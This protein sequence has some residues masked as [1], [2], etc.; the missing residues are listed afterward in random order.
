MAV[1]KDVTIYVD[2]ADLSGELNAAALDLGSEMLDDTR[3]GA[4]TRKNTAGLTTARMAH[5]GYWRA[6]GVDGPDDFLFPNLGT[7]NVPATL[8]PEGASMGG[9]AFFFRTVQG[10]YSLGGQ[11]GALLP[12]S[13]SAEG[14]DGV[15]PTRGKVLQPAGVV[16]ATGTGAAVEIGAAGSGQTIYAALHVLSASGTSPTLDVE[17][18]SDVD[19]TFGTPVTALT[20]GQQSAV[21]SDWQTVAGPNADTHYR[22][23]YTVGGTN[24]EFSFVVVVGII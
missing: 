1:L 15:P 16:T 18:Q 12:F 24:P 4:D 22:V 5:E 10:E 19:N 13:V 9:L 17:V 20:F 8:C 6:N 3:F 11:V 14:S 21:G 2:S 23:S 7:R